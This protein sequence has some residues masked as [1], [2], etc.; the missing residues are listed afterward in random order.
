MRP[1]APETLDRPRS[2]RRV[3]RSWSCH[4]HAIASGPGPARP[5]GLLPVS[6]SPFDS[7]SE[8]HPPREPPPSQGPLRRA[9]C[10]RRAEVG[11]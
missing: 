1:A 7:E 2:A 10:N 11:F 6:E 3:L 4:W 9:G 8:G 5:G